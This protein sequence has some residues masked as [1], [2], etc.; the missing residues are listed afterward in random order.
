MNEVVIDL[1]MI[2][3]GTHP[4]NGDHT[5]LAGE[6]FNLHMN[7][8]WHFEDDDESLGW[9]QSER[10]WCVVQAVRFPVPSAL[11]LGWRGR[12]LK[13]REVVCVRSRQD[14]NGVIVRALVNLGDGG[15]HLLM[16]CRNKGEW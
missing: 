10:M 15:C 16:G 1:S 11:Y 4:L 9:G 8:Q 3:S 13:R 14:G 6:G 5:I 7:A 12:E 2:H